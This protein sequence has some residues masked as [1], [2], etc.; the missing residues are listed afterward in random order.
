M[1]ATRE[2]IEARLKAS[3]EGKTIQAPPVGFTLMDEYEKA[4]KGLKSPEEQEAEAKERVL[5]DENPLRQ[6]GYNKLLDAGASYIQAEQG[7]L[8]GE[9]TPYGG[10]TAAYDAELAFR[11]RQYILGGLFTIGAIAGTAPFIGGVVKSGIKPLAKAFRAIGVDEGIQSLINMTRK[12]KLEKRHLVKTPALSKMK[13]LSDSLGKKIDETTEEIKTIN[14]ER[15]KSARKEQGLREPPLTDVTAT[16]FSGTKDVVQNDPFAR[17]ESGI[18]VPESN[19]PLIIPSTASAAEQARLGDPDYLENITTGGSMNVPLV[20][21]PLPFRQKTYP[22]DGV[23]SFGGSQFYLTR[24]K[25][26][27]EPMIYPIDVVKDRSGSPVAIQGVPFSRFLTEFY[28]PLE[29]TI[30]KL[31]FDGRNIPNEN[32]MIF[33]ITDPT[34]GAVTTTNKPP[35]VAN[36]QGAEMGKDIIQA[37][38]QAYQAGEIGK[39]E[40]TIFKN[41]VDNPQYGKSFRSD[42]PYS[43][44]DME[45]EL[46]DMGIGGVSASV[47]Q[48]YATYQTPEGIPIIDTRL[49]QPQLFDN[50]QNQ[51]RIM[52]IH[53]VIDYKIATLDAK[54]L[55]IEQQQNLVVSHDLGHK[56]TIAHTRFSIND[57][58][59]GLKIAQQKLKDLI[60]EAGESDSFSEF[61]EGIIDNYRKFQK[62]AGEADEAYRNSLKD[63]QQKARK[64]LE[65]IMAKVGRKPKDD[66]VYEPNEDLYAAARDLQDAMDA[67]SDESYIRSLPLAE[68]IKEQIMIEVGKIPNAPARKAFME[69]FMKKRGFDYTQ[70]M[71]MHNSVI[72]SKRQLADYKALT[73]YLNDPNKVTGKHQMVNEFQSDQKRSTAGIVTP[74]KDKD[75][76]A[77]YFGDKNMMFN[78]GE[79]E[80]IVNASPIGEPLNNIDMIHR[81]LEHQFKHFVPLKLDE[82]G[83]LDIFGELEKPILGSTRNLLDHV[84]TRYRLDPTTAR[85]LDTYTPPST[86]YDIARDA[87]GRAAS[88][89]AKNT[90][91]EVRGAMNDITE[92]IESAQKAGDTYAEALERLRLTPASKD[93]LFTEFEDIIEKTKQL[94]LD[95]DP[96]VASQRYKKVGPEDLEKRTIDLIK[97]HM[98]AE[99]I[100]SGVDIDAFETYIKA[101]SKNGHKAGVDELDKLGNFERSAFMGDIQTELEM[102]LVS[103]MGDALPFKG[104]TLDEYIDDVVDSF[105]AAAKKPKYQTAGEL[106]RPGK[107]RREEALL[108]TD[109][110]F[111][112]KLIL[113][114]IAYAKENN[115]SKIVLPSA[116]TH[117]RA[118]NFHSLKTINPIKRI[119]GPQTEKAIEE[120]KKEGFNLKTRKVTNLINRY[121]LRQEVEAER[122]AEPSFI[123]DKDQ[124]EIDVD[125]IDYD[126]REQKFRF[127]NKGGDVGQQTDDM[128]SE[129]EG[130]A[131]EGERLAVDP[132]SFGIKDAVKFIAE[133][134]PIVGDAM[135]AKEIYDELQKPSPDYYT[136]GLLGG[137]AVLGMIPGIGDVAANA[138]K[139]GARQLGRVK[140]DPTALGSNLGNIKIDK[141]E[142][143]QKRAGK[144]EIGVNPFNV[145]NLDNPMLIK[146][147]T[148]KDLTDTD[149][150][151]RANKGKEGKT[152]AGSATANKK[153]DAP[154]KE[155]ESVA[156]RLN[157]N[158]R[159]DKT[160]KETRER[161]N[162]A[163]RLQTIHPVKK[164]GV[165]PDYKS[166]RSYMA[167]VTLENGR[168]DVDQKQRA[169]I[170]ETNVKTPAASIRGTYTTS[171]NVLDE[172]DDS[173]KELGINPK[174]THLFVDMK[175][176]QAVKGFDLATAFRDRV[177]AKGVTYWK[178]I[179]APQPSLASDGS[180][181]L[182]EVRFKF[183]KG[184]TT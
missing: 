151:V 71:K 88:R 142:T 18:Y 78:L 75:N 179:E 76:L 51:Q 174:M 161:P 114:N 101:A 15:F 115:I 116:D 10:A 83:G 125:G 20:N 31:P 34:T 172:M 100:Q 17:F 129:A 122:L 144:G 89:T 138:I 94:D 3:R 137:L 49:G 105:V 30:M 22:A 27:S 134:T 85:S 117:I 25:D 136:V 131:Q 99:V 57:G 107:I 153:I 143:P 150:F 72:R 11:R 159:I 74:I 62:A 46:K 26:G 8:A 77:Y 35:L 164:D 45:A 92:A 133:L 42:Q 29:R 7:V 157:L 69:D 109:K 33:E 91:M 170:I 36:R 56:N 175:T 9:F 13:E 126:P 102:S 121:G 113:T 168:F 87:A 176:G 145:D 152:T 120:L 103:T 81:R 37:V 98:K 132:P 162:V 177:Y 158:S 47:M 1:V 48:K 127:Y 41:L 19:A 147:Y 169:T 4:K 39:A 52:S 140:V 70:K 12:P 24:P 43:L 123:I 66:L 55:P 111:I 63:R 23:E 82:E 165:T 163:N 183:K 184:G 104:N 173:V 130:Y 139:A 93:K 128:L 50:L 80:D 38:D 53:P 178:K 160:V 141:V 155:G 5:A 2:E 166:S 73:E 28:S 6:Y 96:S 60:D 90:R 154:V 54:N 40:Y 119:Y 16:P 180:E 95:A 64:V 61:H 181:L 167:H 97:Q 44:D 84:Q 171:R 59:E 148:K 21:D 32:N 14:E 58:D 146:N 65:D 79:N 110:D 149:N 67:I 182:S 108:Q 156:V 124:I 106:E 68:D 135:A 86:K 118:R 112:K